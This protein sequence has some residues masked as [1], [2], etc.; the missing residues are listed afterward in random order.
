[1]PEWL[2]ST[3]VVAG[4]LAGCVT[5]GGAIL[6]TGIWIGKVNSDRV[7]F[8]EFMKEVRRDIKRI[9][10]RL[11]PPQTI[12]FESPLQL[13]E[14]GKEISET[15]K[16]KSWAREA[17]RSVIPKVEGLSN[18]E[19]QEFCRSYVENEIPGTDKIYSDINEC[20]YER[21]I[22]RERVLDVLMVELRDAVMNAKAGSS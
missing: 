5:V 15:L 11:P 12:A 13:T 6:Y 7:S 17:A 14:F 3:G 20:A 19:I 10:E 2:I 9:F 4:I 1:M 22:P 18:Y 21:G 16:S 8:N